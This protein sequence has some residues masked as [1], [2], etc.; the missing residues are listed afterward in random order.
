MER[1]RRIKTI[2]IDYVPLFVTLVLVVGSGIKEKQSFIK[3]LPVI[4]SLAVYLLM[5]RVNRWNFMLGAINSIVYAIGFFQD[6]LYASVASAL[7]C[8]MP[9]QVASFVMWNKNKYK[10]SATIIKNLSIRHKIFTL[11]I[12]AISSAVSVLVFSKISGTQYVVMD[13]ISF[14][15][16]IF[17]S[18]Y[19]AFGIIDG[20]FISLANSVLKLPFWI[21]I[22]AEGNRANVTYL[23]MAL[24]T[25]LKVS[26]TFINWIKL[27]REQKL[28]EKKNETLEEETIA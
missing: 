16:G 28:L 22:I 27:Y 26:Q 23:I 14:A 21:I 8:S 4:T 20:M 25:L 3:M 11:L 7:L 6:G 15:W 9:I 24:Y 5:A 1:K 10:K 13:G 18:I 19:V 17:S 12:V 2:L